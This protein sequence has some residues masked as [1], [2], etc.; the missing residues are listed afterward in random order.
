MKYDQ[1][2]MKFGSLSNA[3]GWSFV[4]MLFEKS[5]G[6]IGVKMK[7]TKIIVSSDDSLAASNLIRQLEEL[8][9]QVISDIVYGTVAVKLCDKL[10]PDLMIMDVYM[11]SPFDFQ[12]AKTITEANRIPVILISWFFT[13]KS[14]EVANQTGVYSFLIKPVGK[15]N[16]APAIEIAL[17]NHADYYNA[18][19]ELNQLRQLCRDIPMCNS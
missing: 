16:L 2:Q 18:L 3:I 9:Y 8:E 7:K 4:S 19:E 15:C 13:K 6:R 1:L 10:K 14:I 17:K 11:P 5:F 12:I